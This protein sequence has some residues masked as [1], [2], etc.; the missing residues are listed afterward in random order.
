MDLWRF[1]DHKNYTSI[2]LCSQAL[3][4]YQ[5]QRM[6]LMGAQVSRVY[7]EE[8]DL[9]RIKIYC[10]KDTITVAQLLLKYKGEDLIKE[11]NIEFV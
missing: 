2:K 7:W 5:T 3:L 11:E 9:E 4:I 1:G 6:I 10:Q 8:K